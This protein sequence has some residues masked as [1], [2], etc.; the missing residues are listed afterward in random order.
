ML[1]VDH[2]HLPG[3][4]VSKWSE[5]SFQGDYPFTAVESK[6]LHLFPA[7]LISHRTSQI[8]TLQLQQ[9]DQKEQGITHLVLS[10]R[11]KMLKGPGNVE[12]E[13]EGKGL[14]HTGWTQSSCHWPTELIWLAAPRSGHSSS[15]WTVAGGNM[16][17]CWPSHV[18]SLLEGDFPQVKNRISLYCHWFLIKKMLAPN[19]H[20]TIIFVITFHGAI[21]F[22]T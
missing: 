19:Q 8:F 21:L 9:E 10:M 12:S 17:C 14:E 18:S 2:L 1:W 16:C 3:M 5:L 11:V 20:W 22:F 4:F 6:Q 15:A 7:A 13:G